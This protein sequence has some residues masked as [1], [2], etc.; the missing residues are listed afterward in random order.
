MTAWNTSAM[1]AHG[2]LCQAFTPCLTQ[3]RAVIFECSWKENGD[4]KWRLDKQL[5]RTQKCHW[6]YC[7]VV[8]VT[9]DVIPFAC[10]VV[11]GEMTVEGDTAEDTLSRAAFGE[12]VDYLRCSWVNCNPRLTWVFFSTSSTKEA[13]HSVTTVTLTPAN[14]NESS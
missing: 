4:F 8:L 2:Y 9:S 14:M 10:H 1:F 3:Q 6:S 12:A 7:I 11:G 13:Q 5:E